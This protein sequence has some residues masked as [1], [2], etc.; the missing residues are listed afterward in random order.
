MWV[1]GQT[2]QT[3]PTWAVWFR[4]TLLVKR[5]T[6]YCWLHQMYNVA[7]LTL[8]YRLLINAIII[9]LAII[10]ASFPLKIH[11]YHVL[12]Q[13]GGTGGRDF[14]FVSSGAELRGRNSAPFP[15]GFRWLFSQFEKKNPNL[16]KKFFFF[17]F[18]FFLEF[19]FSHHTHT[20]KLHDDN[21]L[22]LHP[23]FLQFNGNSMC[24][25]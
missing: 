8:V 22:E 10:F 20:H 19:S 16:K 5:A 3:A 4:S 6:L 12:I 2:D 11:G 21:L 7:L 14:F 1:W 23:I 9:H 17:F 24:N 13:R 25:S 15:M 18:F